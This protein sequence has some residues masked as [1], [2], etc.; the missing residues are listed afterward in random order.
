MSAGDLY[1]TDFIG[2]TEQQARLLREAAARGTN[3]PF[4]WANLA[5]EVEDLGR[6]EYD[7]ILSQI[8]RI[9]AH[10]LKLEFSPAVDPRA[11]W[12]TSVQD[13][14]REIA[15]RLLRNPGLRPR[16][17]EMLR[18]AGPLAVRAAAEDMEL[19]GEAPA[20]GLARQHGPERYGLAQVLEDWLPDRPDLPQRFN[21]Q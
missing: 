16:L 11:A 14:R 10:L 15:R 18:E 7:A 19:Y 1:D 3:L 13:G 8:I 20:A 21:R 4:D 6:S 12:T 5:E 17:P 2:W 9:V